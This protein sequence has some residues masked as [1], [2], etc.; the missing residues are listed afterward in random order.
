MRD[1]IAEKG[2]LSVRARD[3]ANAIGSVVRA[4]ESAQERV[5]INRGRPLPG[6]LRPKEKKPKHKH[7]WEEGPIGRDPSDDPT[8]SEKIADEVKWEMRDVP[9]HPGVQEQV[10]IDSPAIR[11][12]AAAKAAP[13]PDQPA[14]PPVS[15]PPSSPDDGLT[16]LGRAA[17]AEQQ[18]AQRRASSP[19]TIRRTW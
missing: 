11:A 13:A 7:Y 12:A 5:R 19:Q 14:P 18:A 17:L 16:P 1:E 10:V 9:G 2:A 6:T 15:R 8:E 3:E 4:W